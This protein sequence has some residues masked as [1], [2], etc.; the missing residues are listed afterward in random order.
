MDG[1]NVLCERCWKNMYLP[2]CRRCNLPIEKQAVSSRDGQLK[3][4][5]HKECFNCHTCQKPFPDK[6]FYVL[7]GKP[8]CAY[9]YHEANNSLCGAPSCGQ[10]IEG[11]CA[12]THSGKRYHPEHLLCEFEEGCR[13]RLEEYWEVDCQMLCERHAALISGWS[14]GNTPVG[15]TQTKSAPCTDEGRMMKRM[16]RF[17]DLGAGGDD[18]LDIR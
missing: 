13:E 18:G 5:Y 8:F 12:V 2:K 9:H 17:I 3:G 11:P 16:T 14:R 15:D 7:D 1:G 6:E 4:K 10:P